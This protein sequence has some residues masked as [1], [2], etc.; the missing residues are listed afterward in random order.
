MCL[1]KEI[2]LIEKKNREYSE[3]FK[4]RALHVA[5]DFF[6]L[7]VHLGNIFSTKL[8]AEVISLIPNILDTIL[9][10]LVNIAH[11]KVH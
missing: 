11:R 9:F 1:G 7:D 3:K 5:L 8:W 4:G 6:S 10:E 2:S